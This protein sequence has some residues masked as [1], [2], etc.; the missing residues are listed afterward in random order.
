MNRINRYVFRHLASSTVVAA[1]ALTFAIWLTQSLRLLEVII[2]GAAPI[3][4]FLRLVL[5]ITPEFLVT[6]LPVAFVAA[7][8]FTYY[9]LTVDSELVVLRSCGIGPLGLAQPALA[10]ALTVIGASYL[11]NLYVWPLAAQEFRRLIVLVESEHATVLLREGQFNAID[12]TITVFMRERLETDEL[13]GILIHD[14]RDAE[15][16]V[17]VVA[18]RGIL[19]QTANG[20]RVV[21]FGGNRQVMERDTG[22]LETLYFDQYAIDLQVVRPELAQRWPEASE[23]FLPDLLWPDMSWPNDVP[24]YRTLVAE[25]HSRLSRPLWILAFTT[26]ALGTLIAGE[27]GRRGQGRRVGTAISIIVVLQAI[28]MG[29]IGSARDVSHV[30]PLLYAMPLAAA[31][32]GTMLLFRRPRS[33]SA[34]WRSALAESP[35]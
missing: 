12:D 34:A 8:L 10:M 20:P 2:D 33:D 11:L 31:V 35:A 24:M 15:R 19:T 3:G 17:T 1:A 22:R 25:G 6:V 27:T 26:I 18:E 14:R 5:L 9:R 21:M 28:S 13:H 7:L 30:V 23:R 16:P 4:L 32:G 29:L